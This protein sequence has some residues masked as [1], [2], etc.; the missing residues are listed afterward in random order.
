M[1]VIFSGRICL[2]ELVLVGKQAMMPGW[3]SY[4]SVRLLCIC[5]LVSILC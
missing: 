5:L 3:V 4:L 1:G 2:F